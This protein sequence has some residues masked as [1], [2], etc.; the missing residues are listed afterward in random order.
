MPD[1]FWS[2]RAVEDVRRIAYAASFFHKD[3]ERWPSL[4]ELRTADETLPRRDRWRNEFHIETGDDGVVVSC[5]GPDGQFGTCDD[6]A[7]HPVTPNW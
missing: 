7:S 6:V 3:L 4:A 5:A 1:D 2:A